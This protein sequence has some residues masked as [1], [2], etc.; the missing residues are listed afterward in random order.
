LP[1]FPA[2]AVRTFGKVDYSNNQLLFWGMFCRGV[3]QTPL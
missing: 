1:K 2:P 3:L